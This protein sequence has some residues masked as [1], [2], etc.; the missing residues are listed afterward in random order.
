MSIRMKTILVLS[1]IQLLLC[2]AIFT[3]SFRYLT[4]ENQQNFEREVQSAL[5]ISQTLT[6]RPLL[7]SDLIALRKLL[8]LL[9][10]Q[11]DIT[12]AEIRSPNDI[13]LAQ[14]GDKAWLDAVSPTNKVT[15]QQTISHQ[16]TPIAL[17]SLSFDLTETND[18]MAAIKRNFLILG[19]LSVL[20]IIAIAYVLG[21]Y[22]TRSLSKLER[23]AL[24]IAGGER[25]FTWPPSGNNEISVV[26]QA[27]GHMVEKL[28]ESEHNSAQ[29]QQALEQQVQHKSHSLK[30]THDALTQAQRELVESQKMAAIGV[31]SAGVAHEINNP[32]GVIHSNLQL[33]KEYLT[34]LDTPTDAFRSPSQVRTHSS[35]QVLI[36]EFNECIDD[37]ISSV[38]RVRKIIE[39]LS[40]YASGPKHSDED[41]QLCS[42]VIPLFQAIEE[43]GTLNEIK[44]TTDQ[45]LYDQPKTFGRVK[46]IK[47][48]FIEVLKNAVSACQKTPDHHTKM[49]TIT[50]HQNQEYVT[51]LIHNSGPFISDKD[52]EH[53][54]EPFF[55]TQKVGNGAGLGLTH[56][57][58]IIKRYHGRID[59]A[60][61]PDLGVEVAL[62]FL[63]PN[64]F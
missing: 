16:N 20:F 32:I 61:H 43:L 2:V 15:V 5:S 40:H 3:V 25:T 55:T 22:L 62:K 56:A 30:E 54:F 49:I 28:R 6:I 64:D 37:S 8:T 53:V 12:Y 11:N 21:H 9:V 34:E 44:I 47:Q 58:D 60:N 14:S 24:K 33:C 46:E 50:A 36:D 27:F 18:K 31:M 48:I 10:E 45:S 23:A 41:D 13:V 59:V 19:I 1:M 29:Y 52:L 35:K 51:M 57:Y 7:A 38:D 17:I 39:K 63:I 4:N 26:A 42:L